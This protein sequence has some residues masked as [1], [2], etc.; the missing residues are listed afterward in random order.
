MGK[1]KNKKFKRPQFSADGLPVTV[2]KETEDECV[3]SPA[4]EM[5]EK[6]RFNVIMFIFIN[7]RRVI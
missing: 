3:D 7:S 5:L 1:S 4:G 2:V 6:V